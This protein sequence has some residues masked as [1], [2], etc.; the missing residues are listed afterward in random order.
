[1]LVNKKS[2]RVLVD[3]AMSKL[4]ES[5][6]DEQIRIY[7]ALA[8]TLPTASERDAAA[9]IA[10]ALSKAAALQLDFSKQL[11]RELQWPGHQHDGEKGNGGKS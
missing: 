4:G 10:L 6:I 1:M 9:Q 5:P 11:F 2:I 3:F 8:E 7:H